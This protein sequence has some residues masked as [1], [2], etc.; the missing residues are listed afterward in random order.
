MGPLIVIFGQILQG[1]HVSKLGTDE[2]F[3]YCRG[4]RHSENK[5]W[6]KC[7]EWGTEDMYHTVRDPIGATIVKL[8]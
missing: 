1:K 3:M 8:D 4:L 2:A 7:K 6:R 5:I